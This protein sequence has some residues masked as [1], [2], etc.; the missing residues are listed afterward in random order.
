VEERSVLGLCSTPNNVQRR[1]HTAWAI[2]DADKAHPQV[3]SITRSLDK[4]RLGAATPLRKGLVDTVTVDRLGITGSLLGTVVSTNPAESM[5]EM[6]RDHS[7]RLKN[8]ENGEMALRWAAAG[9]PAAEQQFSR[10]ST[11]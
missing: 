4:N 6:V 3:K 8:R 10:V 7:R 1:L 9:M 5:I 11:A 2:A